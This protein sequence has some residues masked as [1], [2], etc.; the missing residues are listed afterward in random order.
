VREE[1]NTKIDMEGNNA[2]EAS[3]CV[4]YIPAKP[5]VSGGLLL[6]HHSLKYFT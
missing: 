1:D 3:P 2:K 4:T 6:S 5:A